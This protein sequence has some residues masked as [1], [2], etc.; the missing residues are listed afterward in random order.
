LPEKNDERWQEKAIASI[1][2]NL[3]RLNSQNM[4]KRFVQKIGN[5]SAFGIVA[6]WCDLHKTSIYEQNTAPPEIDLSCSCLT[7]LND[8]ISVESFK[9]LKLTFFKHFKFDDTAGM[10][11]EY[12]RI[13]QTLL[14]YKTHI[15]KSSVFSCWLASEQK[16]LQANRSGEIV[17]N[18][19]NV[20]ALECILVDC[21]RIVGMLE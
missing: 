10:F 18:D 2:Y 14:D 17:Q 13:G 12:K 9:A 5:C 6:I 16:V 4:E 3:N 1:I 11:K 7:L 21:V 8:V 19:P 20:D 15:D